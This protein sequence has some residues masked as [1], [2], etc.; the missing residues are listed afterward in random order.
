MSK[1]WEALTTPLLFDRIW[2]S[3]RDK[4][5]DVLRAVAESPYLAPHVHT[6]IGDTSQFESYHEQFKYATDLGRQ[7]HGWWWP[8]VRKLEHPFT[9]VESY[10]EMVEEDRSREQDL[11]KILHLDEYLKNSFAAWQMVARQEEAAIRNDAFLA[12]LCESLAQ[13]PNI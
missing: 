13:M 11:A 12:T 3:L 7:C 5:L 2:I 10:C 9:K 1:Y 4:D 6:V 8:K